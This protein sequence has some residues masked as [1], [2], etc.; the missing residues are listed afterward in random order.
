MQSISSFVS[1]K[2]YNYFLLKRNKILQ[3]E[4]SSG[5]LRLSV[6]VSIIEIFRCPRNNF[7]IVRPS[8]H[9]ACTLWN[10]EPSNCSLLNDVVVA[11]GE[12]MLMF[13]FLTDFQHY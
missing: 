3:V 1:L 13:K 2:N 9:V 4:W 6:P 12:E 8:E 11:S 5:P 7:S 10:K